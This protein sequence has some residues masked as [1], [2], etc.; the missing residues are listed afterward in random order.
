[1]D[2]PRKTPAP[3]DTPPDVLTQRIDSL[4]LPELKAVLSYV[5]RRIEAVR[6]PIGA[7][8]EATAAGEILEIEKQ[9]ACALVKRH[10]PDP[11][12]SGVNTGRALLYHVRRERQF[13]GTE[14]L[15]WTHLGDV[16]DPE[17]IRCDSCG[18]VVDGDASV[19]PRCG[20]E[21]VGH[22]DTEA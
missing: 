11:D 18:G 12:A 13:D 8:I 21:D 3:P 2:N 4:T 10:L 22:S 20:S 17:Q 15:H 5:E 7:E 19:C 16:P 14:S 6:T 1:M 9:G